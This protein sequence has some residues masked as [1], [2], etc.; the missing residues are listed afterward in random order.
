MPV[1][2]FECL[3][4]GWVAA[5]GVPSNNLGTAVFWGHIVD[6]GWAEECRMLLHRE[7]KPFDIAPAV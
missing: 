4:L 3:S 5:V 6:A 2:H 7:R 1:V